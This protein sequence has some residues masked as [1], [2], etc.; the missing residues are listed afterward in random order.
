M[1]FSVSHLPIAVTSPCRSPQPVPQQ[2]QGYAC[3]MRRWQGGRY[4]LT[5]NK[6]RAHDYA[7][8][9]GNLFKA[10]PGSGTASLT[11]SYKNLSGGG[12]SFLGGD[13]TVAQ[14]NTFTFLPG[15]ILTNQKWTGGMNNGQYSGIASTVS[16][17]G[18][19]QGRFNVDRYTITIQR[20][21]GRTQRCFFAFSSKGAEAQLDKGMIFIGDST[22]TLA[23]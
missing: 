4:V 8:Q 17:Q 14:T 20:P 7:L 23:K 5:D 15:G 11:G 9:D 21:D 1:A 3:S 10:H 18:G 16:A 19:G 13:S 6:G 12:N 22:Y 2:T